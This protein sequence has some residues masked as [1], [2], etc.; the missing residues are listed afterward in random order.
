MPTRRVRSKRSSH[1]YYADYLTRFAE[2]CVLA[3][4]L[5]WNAAAVEAVLKEDFHWASG[6]SGTECPAFVFRAIALA[7]AQA[8]LV[9]VGSFVHDFSAEMNPDKRDFIRKVHGE[10]VIFGDLFDV[11]RAEALDTVSRS[12][13]TLSRFLGLGMFICGFSCKGASSLNTAMLADT[14]VH[15]IVEEMVS[16]TGLT[17]WATLLAIDRLRPRCFILE[18]VLGLLRN[19]GALS[20]QH[21][22]RTK[23]YVVAMV[24]LTPAMFGFPNTRPRVFFLGLRMDLCFRQPP[25]RVEAMII[26]AVMR[27]AEM[28]PKLAVDDVILPEDSPVIEDR[29]QKMAEELLQPKKRR[30]NEKTE[31]AKWPQKHRALG[32]CSPSCKWALDTHGEDFPEYGLLPARQQEMLDFIGISFPDARPTVVGISQSNVSHGQEDSAPTITPCGDFWITHRARRLIGQECLHM[33]GIFISPEQAAEFP[34]TLL[35]DLAGNSFNT[36]NIVPCTLALL[37]T[38]AELEFDKNNKPDWLSMMGA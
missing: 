6:C 24:Q 5:C 37:F 25:Q 22:L 2:R 33:Q 38:M 34:D 9:Q 11:S 28:Q 26:D 23:G 20:V 15:N 19:G 8:G 16:S 30:R 27:Q 10:H 21:A 31:M 14:S 12:L 13:V 7:L 18:N 1:P 29:R 17:F 32:I 35:R 3:V 36:W 4:G